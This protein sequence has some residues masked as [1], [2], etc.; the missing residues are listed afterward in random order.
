[1]SAVHCHLNSV[2]RCVDNLQCG[3]LSSRHAY[4]DDND[5]VCVYCMSIVSV[6]LLF[7]KFEL[8]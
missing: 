6:S 4:D 5:D 7:N 8:I 3:Q 2:L 1:M